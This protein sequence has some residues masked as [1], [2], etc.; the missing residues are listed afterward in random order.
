MPNGQNGTSASMNGQAFNAGNQPQSN[1]G[2]G[3]AGNYQKSDNKN[4][5]HR[6]EKK[7]KNSSQVSAVSGA[8]ITDKKSVKKAPAD[9]TKDEQKR[10]VSKKNAGDSATPIKEDSVTNLNALS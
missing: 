6:Y 4:S 3:K 5:Q 7:D 10:Y 2:K 9:K 8:S 1:Q